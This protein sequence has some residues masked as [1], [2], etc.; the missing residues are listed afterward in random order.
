MAVCV[1]SGGIGS[2]HCHRLWYYI[3]G[4]ASTNNVRYQTPAYGFSPSAVP[5]R[6]LAG[7]EVSEER[8]QALPG[9]GHAVLT[10]RLS[11][12]RHQGICWQRYSKPQAQG[13]DVLHEPESANPRPLSSGRA[14]SAYYTMCLYIPIDLCLYLCQY[15]HIYIAYVSIHI[16]TLAHNRIE[17]HYFEVPGATQCSHRDVHKRR[18]RSRPPWKARRLGLS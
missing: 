1:H 4:H 5:N 10:A 9:W 13:L 3:L 2:D 18:G 14:I 6:C 8:F 17:R 15:I 12:M 7:P 16:Y 11:C